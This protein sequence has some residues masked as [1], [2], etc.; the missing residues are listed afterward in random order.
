MEEEEPTYEEREPEEETRKTY[1]YVRVEK[2][3]STT[4]NG[5]EPYNSLM[6]KSHLLVMVDEKG[7]EFVREITATDHINKFM[8]Q[9]FKDSLDNGSFVF[10]KI[11]HPDWSGDDDDEEAKEV[12]ETQ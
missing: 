3:V 11:P 4:E 6:P 1:S 9:S 2:D 8:F 10:P 12:T 5:V 7:E